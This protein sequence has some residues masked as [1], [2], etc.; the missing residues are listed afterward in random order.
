LP[1]PRNAGLDREHAAR[2]AEKRRNPAAFAS[3]GPALIRAATEPYAGCLVKVV[4]RFLV[5][6]PGPTRTAE[7]PGRG[8][9]PGR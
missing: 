7:R 4:A 5:S 6:N 1:G 9:G 2:R 3:R 8:D